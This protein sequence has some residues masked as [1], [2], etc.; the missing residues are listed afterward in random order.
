MVGCVSMT[1]ATPV[2]TSHAA[3]AVVTAAASVL[4]RVRGDAGAVD[5]AELHAQQHDAG[6][7]RDDVA[8]GMA[9]RQPRHVP[10]RH[11]DEHHVDPH[12]DGRRADVDERRRPAVL[13]SVEGA[14]DQLER[15]EERQ[16]DREA[17]ERARDEPGIGGAG[18][19][20]LEQQRRDGTG[21]HDESIHWAERYPPSTSLRSRLERSPTGFSDSR[22]GSSSRLACPTYVGG[23]CAGALRPVPLVNLLTEVR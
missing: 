13:R 5:R 4:T 16:A 22:P 8:R 6:A 12:R 23:P 19:A 18:R 14:R 11:D 15:R 1:A 17:L 3:S 7:G 10:A 20:V 21:Q 9:E 2:A